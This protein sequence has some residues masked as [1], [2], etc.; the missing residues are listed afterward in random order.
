MHSDK[1]LELAPNSAVVLETRAVVLAQ[2]GQP[3]AA[4]DAI[5]DALRIS[6]GAPLV[7]LRRAEILYLNGDRDSAIVEL[8]ELLN[9]DVPEDVRQRANTFLSLWQA[10]IR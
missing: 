2:D 4:L 8:K 10:G 3:T 6:N 9:S 1:A 7:M 5:D